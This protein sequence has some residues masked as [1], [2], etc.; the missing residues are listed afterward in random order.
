MYS[1]VV[2]GII[3]GTN[4]QIT[5]TVWCLLCLG[6]GIFYFEY[7]RNADF[8]AKTDVVI[9]K[10]ADFAHNSIEKHNLAHIAGNEGFPI[11]LEIFKQ[12]QTTTIRSFL[13]QLSDSLKIKR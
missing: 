4:I 1:F 7:K 10:A 2:L 9:D 11:Q 13:R 8:H 6:V 5:F 3:P 12:Q